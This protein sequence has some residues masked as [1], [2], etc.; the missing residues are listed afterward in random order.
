V[1]NLKFLAPTVPEIQRRY[2]NSKSKSRDPSTT[3]KYGV[4]DDPIFAYIDPDLLI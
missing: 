1:P 2:Q 3:C 4:V